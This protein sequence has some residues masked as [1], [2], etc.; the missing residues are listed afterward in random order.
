ME[1]QEQPRRRPTRRQVLWAPGLA[2][3]LAVAVLISYRYDKTLW[4]W[5]KLLIV[6]AVIAGGGL[7]FNRQQRERELEI[8]REPRER[9]VE[10][11]D[12]RAQERSVASVPRSDRKPAARQGWAA[13][14]V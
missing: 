13:A 14:P 12:R 7:W 5:M 11:A 8:A 1:Q 6:P 2:A 9:D 3:V 10:I 4:D